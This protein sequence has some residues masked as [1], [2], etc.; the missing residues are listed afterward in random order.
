[1]PINPELLFK[2][3]RDIRNK[4]IFETSYGGEF[5]LVSDEKIASLTAQKYLQNQ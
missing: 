5:F 4:L 2:I 1:M 3:P